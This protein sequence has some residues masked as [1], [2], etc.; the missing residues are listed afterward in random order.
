MK[1]VK[2]VLSAIVAGYV[3]YLG[4]ATYTAKKEVE[5]ISDSSDKAAAIAEK[6]ALCAAQ[7]SQKGCD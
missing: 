5:N 3:V 1:K 4:V 7:P 6:D 2:A